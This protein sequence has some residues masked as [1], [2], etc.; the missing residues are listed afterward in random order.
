MTQKRDSAKNGH[1]DLLS[2]VGEWLAML[3][4]S[5]DVGSFLEHTVSL[6]ARHLQADVC[7]IYL[8]EDAAEVLVLRATVGLAPSAVGRIRMRLGEGLV[9]TALKELRPVRADSASS[10]PAFKHF[11]EAGE[12]GFDAFLAVPI[13]R[14]VEKIGV[15]VVQRGARHPFTDHDVMAMRA[16]GSQLAG[17]IETARVMLDLHAQVPEGQRGEIPPDHIKGEAAS[18]HSAV[19]V[20][21]V[22]RHRP[23]LRTLLADP[24][25]SFRT[26]T[27]TDLEEALKETAGQLEDL[28]AHMGARIPELAS[29]IFDAHLMML[30]DDSFVGEMYRGVEQ[31]KPAGDAVL[32]T[33]CHYMDM[34]GASPHDYTREKAKDVEDL[35]RRILYNLAT[36][37]GDLHG[38]FA[39]RVLIARDLLPS[40]MLKA[41]VEG[42][43]AIVLVGGGITSHI[44]ILARSLQ[45]PTVIV[46]SPTLLSMPD[47]TP[48]LIDA[49]AGNVLI[50]PSEEVRES[51][52]QKERAHRTVEA[53]AD[54]MQPETWTSDCTR[55][56]L[57]ANIN[58]LSEMDLAIALKAEGVG[59]YRTEFPFLI[60]NAFP[61][62][63]DQAAIYR[64]LF[65]RMEGH[66][67]TVRTVD[68]GGDK[69]LAYFDMA[70]EANPALGLRSTR[71]ALQYPDILD[72]QLSA[73]LRA[74]DGMSQTRVMFPMIGSLDEFRQGRGRLLACYEELRSSGE[75]S[76]ELPEI[77]TMIEVPAL[78]E[79]IDDLAREAD[80]FSIGTNDFVQYMLAVDRTNERVASYYCPHHPAVL[81]S[82]ARTVWCIHEHAKDVAVCGEMAHDPRYIP[83]FLGI[84]IRKLSVD[85]SFLP[86]VQQTVQAWSIP[87]AEAYARDLLGQNTVAEVG[88]RLRP[89]KQDVGPPVAM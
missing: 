13:Q 84:G 36:V 3:A 51:Y 11:P 88:K 41:A 24:A 43:A 6:V 60:R 22:L 73:I 45:I 34:F 65:E 52:E 72:R 10:H 82:L 20:S 76:G 29:L 63:Q 35:A 49:D 40:D 55:V 86:Q 33:A 18:A 58:L 28:Q 68:L 66:Q 23:E 83:F 19:G 44:S 7:S 42:V 61:G 12:E 15:L 67:V 25:S 71:L 81:R 69:V 89:T 27:R 85:P 74:A 59:L 87:D 14:G 47:G 4:G 2:S 39:G 21:A 37:E 50:S 9:G 78:V 62:E 54:S 30:R 77:G 5:T 80:F 75:I 48:M 70:G 32:E 16:L 53:M 56:S 57:M 38:G 79:I 26:G 1:L 31:G 64:R 8:Y 17:A 46:D